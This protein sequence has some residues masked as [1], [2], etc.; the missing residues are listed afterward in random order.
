MTN[1]E[2]FEINNVPFGDVLKKWPKDEYPCISAWLDSER[3]QKFK[4]GDYIIRRGYDWIGVVINI[5][6]KVYIRKLSKDGSLLKWNSDF[7]CNN[8]WYKD[9]RTVFYIDEYIDECEKIF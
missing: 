8:K 7:E 4:I 2:Y 6:D 1:K 5:L 9:D 3:I